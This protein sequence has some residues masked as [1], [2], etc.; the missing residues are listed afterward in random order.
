MKPTSINITPPNEGQAVAFAG[1]NYRIL[2]GGE[3]TNN[4]LGVID[5]LVPPNAG[6]VPHSHPTIQESF[7]VIEGELTFRTETQT[8]VAKKGA[9]IE[10]PFGGAIHNFKNE[11]DSIARLL[12]LV[13]PS[14]L[15]KM[16][17]ELG[18]PVAVG[19]LKPMTPPSP[20]QLQRIKEATIKYQ[21]EV[22]PPDY[23]E[24]KK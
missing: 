15:E 2:L 19:E 3:E 9:F 24:Q 6:P 10:I 7:F 4:A 11:T 8:Y 5:M 16:F 12:C 23:F 21:Q 20:E 18:T 22:F 1:G 13:T 14:G 17:R